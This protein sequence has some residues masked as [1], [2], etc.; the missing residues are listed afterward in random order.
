VLAGLVGLSSCV[1]TSGKAHSADSISKS[2]LYLESG[3]I[4]LDPMTIAGIA[5]PKEKDDV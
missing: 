4:G 1:R 3:S 5:I 2:P